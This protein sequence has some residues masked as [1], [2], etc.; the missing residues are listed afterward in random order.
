MQRSALVLAKLDDVAA[1]VDREPDVVGQLAFAVAESI[2]SQLHEVQPF[3][4]REFSELRAHQRNRLVA[5]QV[6][7]LSALTVGRLPRVPDG[8]YLPAS[9]ADGADG[10]VAAQHVDKPDGAAFEDRPGEQTMVLI[11]RPL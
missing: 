1:L 9:H 2:E 6:D 10:G 11:R 3:H 4:L 5:R 8:E 7:A